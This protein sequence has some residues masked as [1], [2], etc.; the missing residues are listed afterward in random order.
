ME[1]LAFKMK[2]NKGQKTAYIKRHKEIWPEL[3]LLRY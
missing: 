1:R 2:L 3:K